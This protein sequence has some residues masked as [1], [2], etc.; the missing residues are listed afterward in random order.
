MNEPQKRYSKLELNFASFDV[1]QVYRK[2]RYQKILVL[3]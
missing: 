3:I 2:E 1:K